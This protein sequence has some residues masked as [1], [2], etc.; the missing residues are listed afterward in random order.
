MP[1][2][3]RRLVTLQWFTSF[4]ESMCI[5]ISPLWGTWRISSAVSYRMEVG[6]LSSAP[7]T[8]HRAKKKRSVELHV[9]TIE[10]Y[11]ICY[12]L[13]N[14]SPPLG[15]AAHAVRFS[16]ASALGGNITLN[17]IKNKNDDTTTLCRIPSIWTSSRSTIHLYSPCY[18]KKIKI[19][20]LK[21]FFF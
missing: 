17:V 13:Y 3:T 19:E 9:L 11:C 16:T 14:L 1:Q 20:L 18:N 12:V 8:V 10:T 15:H 2:A 5:L 6:A 4:L 7:H 21:A